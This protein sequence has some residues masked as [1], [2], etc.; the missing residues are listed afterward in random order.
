MSEATRHLA[1]YDSA[2]RY[3]ATIVSSERI[4]PEAS[5]EE[6]R[7]LVLDVE[8]PH[9]SF[10]LGQ[11]VG[12]IVAMPDD[13]RTAASPPSTATVHASVRSS[14]RTR[15]LSRSHVSSTRNARPATSVA[16]CTA[17]PSC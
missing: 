9:F 16:P 12:V 5:S 1:E 15:T 6:V 13:R 4:T 11:S 7:E 3:R 8:R 10:Q 17:S 14:R 2:E